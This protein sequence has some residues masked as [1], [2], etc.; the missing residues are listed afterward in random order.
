MTQPIEN[1]PRSIAEADIAN[2]RYKIKCMAEAY[3]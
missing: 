2:S 1:R 3:Y